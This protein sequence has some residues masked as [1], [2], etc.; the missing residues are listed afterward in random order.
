MTAIGVDIGGTKTLAG[1]V[2]AE[3]QVVSS[4][5]APTPSA[6]GPD[7]VL[8]TAAEL[9]TALDT[10]ADVPVGVGAA[11]TI[12]HVTGTVRFAT[13]HLPKWTGTAVADE[14]HRRTGRTVVV[15]NDV[16]AAALAEARYGVG[17]DHDHLLLVAVGTGLGGGLISGGRVYRGRR[18]AALEIAHLYVG[19]TGDDVCGCGRTGHLEAVASGTGIAQAY[20]RASGEQTSTRE[21]AERARAGEPT[22]TEVLDHAGD[23]LGRAL[24]G[25]VALFDVDVVAL[26][27]SV[28][29]A[30]LARA[31]AAFEDDLF[32]AQTD[33]DLLPV[34]LGANAVVVGAALM[35]VEGLT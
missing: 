7:A 1:L 25:C 18:N 26:G 22:A 2:N 35:A 17:R 4:R 33:V 29:P 23:T 19:A 8:A 20:A 12:D 34:A 10:D 6:A 16:N 5:Q 11:G 24:A 15:D 21:V 9:V 32:V 14:L 30:L 13:D 27:G 31:T 3:G 28:G